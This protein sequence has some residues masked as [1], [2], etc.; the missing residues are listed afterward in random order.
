MFYGFLA[1]AVGL[2][3]FGYVGFVVIGQLLILIG[4][5]LRWPWI[6]NLRFRIIH[7][8]MILV[9]ALES[10]GQVM[11][12]LTTWENDL[13]LLAGQTI[14]GDSFVANLLN[15]I[16][17]C[18]DIGNDHWAF[19]SGYVSFAAIV[20]VTFFLAPPLRTL[21]KPGDLKLKRG[22]I[23]A[24]LLGTVGFIFIY[25]AW[26]M[27]S[28]NRSHQVEINQKATEESAGRDVKP[29]PTNVEDRLPIYFL[30]FTGINFL[31]MAIMIWALGEKAT[32]AIRAP[33]VSEKVDPST[34]L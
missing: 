14:V 33:S 20:V 21:P 30:T 31:G 8:V 15:K 18:N 22:P 23:A 17:F 5:V 6:R 19:Q 2:I 26:C 11:C 27:D 4:M 9:V 28:F 32:F 12:P 10:L 3:H 7:L 1:D 24:A 16:M 34:H 13:R 25:T 29:I